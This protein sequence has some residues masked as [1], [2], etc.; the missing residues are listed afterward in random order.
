MISARLLKSILP[1][2]AALLLASPVWARHSDQP[3]P[4]DLAP[5]PPPTAV[6]PTASGAYKDGNGTVHQWQVDSG[7]M[8][9]W[10][11]QPYLPAGGVFEP[12]YW[13]EDQTPANWD[14]DAAALG[15]LKQNHVLDIYLY[16]PQGL[17]HVPP[18]AVQ[19]T[20]D[21]LEQNGFRYGIEIGDRPN[22]L[23]TGYIIKPAVL[24][25]IPSTDTSAAIKFGQMT[26][27]Q[28][29]LYALASLSD[30][31]DNTVNVGDAVTDDTSALVPVSADAAVDSVVLL[32]PQ[33]QFGPSTREGHLPDLWQGYDDYRDQLLSFFAKI[34]LGKGFRFFIDPFT[35]CIGMNGDVPNLVP[36]S[37]GFRLAFQA[38]LENKYK[39]VDDLNRGWGIKQRD[40]PDFATAA[41]CIPL[42]KDLRG[43]PSVYDPD[44]HASYAVINQ[45]TI[46]SN[47]WDDIDN[48]KTTSV[49]G[50]MNGIADVLKSAVAD[51]P[52]VFKVASPDKLFVNDQ[53][54]GGFDGLGIEAFGH[55]LD[56]EN[57]SAASVYAIAEQSATSG[58]LIASDTD[59]AKPSTKTTAGYLS[60]TALS[61]DW[62]HL[63]DGGARGI[64]A[65]DLQ[66]LPA[67]DKSMNLS[68]MPIQLGWISAYGAG[69]AQSDGALLTQSIPVLWY[70]AWAVRE[71]PG[72]QRLLD[73][74]W[75]LPSYQTGEVV[76]LG[77]K[78]R[79]YALD[80]P[81]GALPTFV[82]WSPHNALS[83]ISFTLGKTVHPI[84]EDPLGNVLKFKDKAGVLTVPIGDQPIVVKHVNKLP[85]PLEIVDDAEHEV[86][87]LLDMA[88]EK[89]VSDEQ[90]R[91]EFDYARDSPSLTDN[92]E[93]VKFD[94][95]Q[96]VIVM[97]ED[98]LRPYA[99]IE[100][101]AATRNS[102][103]AIVPD[104]DASGGA[105]LALD[106][107][108]DPP[109]LD[110]GGSGYSASYDFSVNVS[111]RYALWFAG[112]KLDGSAAS[113]FTYAIDDGPFEHVR[114]VPSEGDPYGKFYWSELGEVTIDHA[115]RHKL[116]IVV[117]D[118]RAADGHYNL[119]ID[120]LCLTNVVFHPDGPN[121]PPID[122]PPL[123]PP[124]A[125][126]NQDANTKDK[127][128]KNVTNNDMD[129]M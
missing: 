33:Q 72:V 71:N 61:D 53:T 31:D 89:K 81:D 11:G 46:V 47:Y 113:E 115:G 70:P 65:Y 125:P 87:H 19:R 54:V 6:K 120:T 78:L 84:I 32:Y 129:N 123:V 99:W 74:V 22:D 10:D 97:L 38:W 100:G 114:E 5:L 59:D 30:S 12:H 119:S 82:I 109:P 126:P 14:A 4:A 92:D 98:V 124:A 93:Q 106:N 101:E 40:L 26:G 63:R 7:H 57:K 29:A 117:D 28:S 2:A 69:F 66:R 48:F 118:R 52:V 91:S 16:A 23:L 128:N 43:I 85:I 3:A 90:F 110:S 86:D 80:D 51:V 62:D 68:S 107:S 73:G 96:R 60:N 17:T 104:I 21:Y 1:L 55:G 35:D 50:Y 102:F 18:A 88:D 58:W 121:P 34:H 116:T 75:W 13:V 95:Y 44:K 67:A 9:T 79:A 77:S 64:F 56:L 111:G 24:R 37:D 39:T 127:H 27:V 83:Q 112:S 94:R 15:A 36:T 41:R 20:L 108:K 49:R 122:A 42:W 25:A 76:P 8:L 45:P 105:Y 103:D